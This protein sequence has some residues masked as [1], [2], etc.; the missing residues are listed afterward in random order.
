M[1]KDKELYEDLN[2]MQPEEF[3]GGNV[4]IAEGVWIR[5]DGTM[6]TE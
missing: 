4:Y 6:Y 3:Q 2:E 1:T 5:P